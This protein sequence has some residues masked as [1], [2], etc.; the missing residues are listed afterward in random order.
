MRRIATNPCA[1]PNGYG[2]SVSEVAYTSPEFANG[3]G[4]SFVAMGRIAYVDALS[5]R[6]V[7]DS[8]TFAALLRTLRSDLLRNTWMYERWQCEGR[9]THNPYYHEYPEVVAMIIRD[10]KYGID[11]GFSTITVDPFLE[12]FVAE[13]AA[14]GPGAVGGAAR[15]RGGFAPARGADVAFH[16]ELGGVALSYARRRVA[17]QLK[18][19][20][21]RTRR[22]VVTGLAPLAAYAWATRAGRVGS[23]Q[24]GGDGAETAV[25]TN[26]RGTLVLESVVCG[27]ASAHIEITRVTA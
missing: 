22:I 8:A 27:G 20:P 11:I 15:R 6:R 23:A 13:T 9:P 4:D 25:A 19:L 18:R 5:L 24:R 2:T 3:M 26:V 21:R 12:A 7:N 16:F 1:R 14:G 17:L 10:V